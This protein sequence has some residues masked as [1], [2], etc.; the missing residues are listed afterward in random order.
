MALPGRSFCMR[1]LSRPFRDVNL[2]HIQKAIRS[3][4]NY[5]PRRSE[6]ENYCT[7]CGK[8]C[9]LTAFWHCRECLDWFYDGKTRAGEPSS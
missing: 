3:S 6:M 8:W 1:A 9:R 4:Q 5:N 7:S 2:E